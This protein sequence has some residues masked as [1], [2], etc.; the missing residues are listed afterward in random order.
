MKNV[1]KD[2]KILIVEDEIII[3][4][5]IKMT[6]HELGYQIAGIIQNAKSVLTYLDSQIPDVII[7]DI[8]LEGEMT[9]IELS[10]IINQKYDIPI[11]FCS[12]YNDNETVDKAVLTNPY[13]YIL[14]PIEERELRATIKIA[15]YKQEMTKKL[16][17]SEERWQF[18]L[19][20]SGDTV[21]D[22]DI[23][24]NKVFFSK[25][26]DVLTEF[27]DTWQNYGIE[28]WKQFIH[29]NDYK[30]VWQKIKAHLADETQ[31]FI[32]EYRIITNSGKIIWVLNRA[33]IMQRDKLKQPVRMLGTISDISE[34]KKTEEYI[35]QSEKKYRNLVESMSEGI[36]IVDENE[37]FLFV[38]DAA[39]AIFGFSKPELQKMNLKDFLS[40]DELEKIKKQTKF[41]KQNKDGQYELIIT[42]SKK[43][44]RILFVKVKPLFE[45]GKFIGSFGI[46][47]DITEQRKFEAEMVKQARLESLG[48]LAGGIAHDFN[49]LLTAILSNIE[50]ASLNFSNHAILKR[51]LSESVSAIKQAKKLTG[52]LLTFAKGGEPVISN[53]NISKLMRETTDFVLRGSNVKANLEIDV[54]VKSILADEGQINQIINNLLINARQAMPNGGVINISVKNLPP[55]ASQPQMVEIVIQ[56]SGF[57]IPAENLPLIFDPFFTTKQ[58]GTG[59]GLSTTYSI[60]KKHKGSIKID[61]LLNIGTKISIQL[62]ATDE[63]VSEQKDYHLAQQAEKGYKILILDDNEMILQV[64]REMLSQFGHEIHIAKEGKE[65]IDLYKKEMKKEAPFDLLILDLT[66]PNGWGGKEVVTELRKLNPQVK[67]IVSSGYS[68]API[69]SNFQEYGF[70]GALSKP[71]QVNDI[72]QVISDVMNMSD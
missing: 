61:S 5:D 18:A 38:N 19:E 57:G 11:I 15:L 72:L 30:D 7:M 22:W 24:A 8:M 64:T 60:V 70:S 68:S 9:G 34:R 25:Q 16:L 31:L 42:N 28:S 63:V 33:K 36:G 29:P 52:Q 32:A 6:L 54:H 69:I 49:N 58:N 27:S 48:I 40:N 47:S 21:W 66:I 71:Y 46:F 62:P 13:G 67:A 23:L 44:E 3:A 56:D 12:A 20:G 65:A 59:L 10:K 51:T 2:I 53:V 1:N 50:Y 26:W 45:H 55:Q 35:I 37:N 17:K 4:E 14:K 39:S 41:R 43:Q